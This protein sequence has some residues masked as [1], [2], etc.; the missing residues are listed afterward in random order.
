MA[1]TL[2]FKQ[3]PD[4]RRQNSSHEQQQS[5]SP[6]S[7]NAGE[8]GISSSVVSLTTSGSIG[9]NS[10]AIGYSAVTLEAPTGSLCRRR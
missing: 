7:F 3:T 10:A 5:V 6:G 4:E 2:N 8:V 1:L 9:E